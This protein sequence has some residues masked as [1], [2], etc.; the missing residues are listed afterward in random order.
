MGLPDH[1][2]YT[3]D[4][5]RRREVLGGKK[6]AVIAAVEEIV[7]QQVD[8]GSIRPDSWQTDTSTLMLI[9]LEERAFMLIPQDMV[10][11][12]TAWVNS[13]V[14]SGFGLR[15]ANG[16]DIVTGDGVHATMEI[17]GMSFDP[18]PKWRVGSVVGGEET[19]PAPMARWQPEG[20]RW[21]SVEEPFEVGEGEV[22]VLT[23]GFTIPW[24]QV[25]IYDQR[26][27]GLLVSD[28]LD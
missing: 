19:S 26:L 15:G 7:A 14:L 5:L 17:D 12:V 3:E 28:M 23:V 27:G 16:V 11:G 4:D 24:Y 22:V 20:G 21:D 2:R 13:Q 25:E 10:D 8:G 1:E 9:K 6:D 18:N